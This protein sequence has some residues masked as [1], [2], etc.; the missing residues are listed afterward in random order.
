M[1]GLDSFLGWVLRTVTAA[2]QAELNDDSELRERL[3]EAELRRHAGGISDSDF[4]V[5]PMSFGT[6]FKTA[7]EL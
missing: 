1:F 3:L 5:I 7:D 4:T 6:I 2:A